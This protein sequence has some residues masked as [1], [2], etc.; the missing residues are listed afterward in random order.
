M[1][2]ILVLILFFS[3]SSHSKNTRFEVKDAVGRNLVL[4]ISEAPLEK[5]FGF[6][7]FITGWL[8]FDLENICPTLQGEFKVDMRTFDTGIE[9]RNAHLRDKFLTTGEFP[10]AIFTFKKCLNLS[11]GKILKGD[12]IDIE[13][14][15]N[16]QIRGISQMKSLHLFLNYF[17]ETTLTKKRLYGNLLKLSTEFVI[18]FTPF[19]IP[20]LEPMK[21][22]LSS[23]ARVSVD[24]VA[25]DASPPEL[26]PIPDDIK[27]K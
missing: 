4:F 14:E 23:E 13:M 17:K 2:L 15:G 21:S 3:L 12:K 25:T 27:P 10:F 18:P 9:L 24:L 26:I 20:V 1:R 5:T 11:S 19:G 7:S 6:T 16:F 8:E 22:V